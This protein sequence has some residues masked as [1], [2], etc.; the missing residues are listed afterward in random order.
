MPNPS[1]SPIATNYSNPVRTTPTSSL[2]PTSRMGPTP[3]AGPMV[4][5]LTTEAIRGVAARGFAIAA[6]AK[7]E[8]WLFAYHTGKAKEM[9]VI[10]PPANKRLQ[11]SISMHVSGHTNEAKKFASDPN[12]T[13]TITVTSPNGQRQQMIVPMGGTQSKPVYAKAVD[14]EFDI[15]QP[16]NY[17]VDV[18][19]S[20]TSVGGYIEGREY[21]VHVGKQNFFKPTQPPANY[22]PS[23]D[24]TY[25][26]P[27]DEIEFI[28]DSLRQRI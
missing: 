7:T 6:N 19:P 8:Q 2:A 21:R 12:E 11:L 9:N 5:F 17:I 25:P 24:Q 18:T 28:A 13:F 14:I 22:K 20:A 26:Y 3:W 15:S 10:T 23:K 16:G 1:S 27:I 4:R